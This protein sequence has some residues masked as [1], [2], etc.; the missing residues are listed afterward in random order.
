MNIFKSDTKK[1]EGVPKINIYLLRALFF[2]MAVFLA[3]DSWSYIFNFEGEWNPMEAVVW[4]SWAAFSLIAILGIIHP[5]KMLPIVLFEIIYKI[6]WLVIVAYPLWSSNQLKDSPAEGITYA[7]LWV[8]LPV[9]AMPWKY[10]V[11]KYILTSKKS[12][13]SNS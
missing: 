3:K 2:L 6:I 10:F 4:S 13:D 8:L 5:L 7:F 12:D 1:W 11:K 9:V